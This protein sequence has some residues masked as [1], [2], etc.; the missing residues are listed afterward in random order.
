MCILPERPPVKAH[1]EISDQAEEIPSWAPVGSLPT[2]LEEEE[3]EDIDATGLM[4][5]Q[6]IDGVLALYAECPLWFSWS[7]FPDGPHSCPVGLLE[8]QDLLCDE[9][10]FDD[11]SDEELD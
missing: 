11:T 10:I 3:L 7:P 2:I 4:W 1:W 6:T 8:I 9:S 5:I